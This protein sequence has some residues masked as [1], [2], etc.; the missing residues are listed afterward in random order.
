MDFSRNVFYYETNDNR[1]S[2]DSAP[3][4]ERITSILRSSSSTEQ[5]LRNLL[6]IFE[7][8]AREAKEWKRKYESLLE[9]QENEEMLKISEVSEWRRKYEE[10]REIENSSIRTR[11]SVSPSRKSSRAVQSSGKDLLLSEVEKSS[12]KEDNAVRQMRKFIQSMAKVRARMTGE[13]EEEQVDVVK[14][15][16]WVKDHFE[17]HVEMKV[18]QQKINKRISELEK[19]WQEVTCLFPDEKEDKKVLQALVK[20]RDRKGASSCSSIALKKSSVTD[21]R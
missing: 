17:R 16:G 4:S 2:S 21:R 10:L 9:K 3:I 12:V 14:L 20:L 15:W 1:E 5:K 13:K 18:N 6:S 8:Q 19:L 11:A 7:F